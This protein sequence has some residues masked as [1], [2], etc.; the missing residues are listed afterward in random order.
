M[1]NVKFVLLAF[2]LVAAQ[3]AFA[4]NGKIRGTTYDRSNGEP[5]WGVQVFVVG[6]ENGA[7]ADF[8]G[9]F[10][11]S[12]APGTYSVQA[13]FIGT[14]TVTIKDVIV[15]AGEVT[16]L[17]A[18]WME[19]A[20]S[21]LEDIIVTAEA[22]RTTDIALLN[23]KKKS[24]NLIDGISSQQIKRSGDSDVAGAI[25]RVPGVSIQ[26]GQYV[27]VRGLGDRYTKTILNGVEVPGLDPDR[28]AIQID[29]FPTS[30]IDN[31]IVYKNFTP[32]LSADFVGGT[33]NIETKEFP[34]ERTMNLSFSLEYNPSMHLRNDFLGYQGGGTDFLGFDDG[35]RDLP[36][37]GRT[38]DIPSPI[39]RDAATENITRSFNQTMATQQQSNFANMSLGFSIGDQ[40]DW[41]GRKLGYIGAINYNS[42]STFFENAVDGAS[43]KPTQDDEFALISDTRFQGA[44]GIQDAQLSGLAGLSLKSDKNKFRFQ[45]MHIQNG[46]QRAAQRTRIRSNNNFN[47]SLV[48]NLEYTERFLTNFLIAGEHYF[49]G[50]ES[51][52]EWK[53]SPTFSTIN[54]LLKLT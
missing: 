24:T 51:Q 53:V 35:T 5:M 8:D 30:L 2:L 45:A 27:F 44:L 19:E 49:K 11:I 43:V 12:V 14:V 17:D 48:D 22:I 32:N 3:A 13:K 9:K 54:D 47:T 46:T 6:T 10:E 25:K 29:I 20:A 33:V 39:L 42:T 4:Q 38:S 36:F 1:K 15:K 16:L 21:E 23:V 7:A 37:D 40:L 31:I 34:D 41:K 26:G 50:N 28:N 52:L 18:I